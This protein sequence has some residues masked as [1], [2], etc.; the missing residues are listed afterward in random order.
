MVN[1]ENWKSVK[2][3]LNYR[4]EVDLLSQQSIRLEESWLRH[5]L[6]WAQ[7]S[8]L[9]NQQVEQERQRLI[10]YFTIFLILILVIINI[11]LNSINR[12]LKERLKNKKE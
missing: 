9:K 5:L 4:I 8:S 10:I 12:R 6:E 1:R 3:Y 2:S 11:R 7:E